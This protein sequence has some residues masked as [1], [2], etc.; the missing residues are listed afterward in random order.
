MTVR[1][2]RPEDYRI[3]VDIGKAFPGFPCWSEQG[4][5]EENN[6]SHSVTLT[7]EEEGKVAGFI[8]FWLV[9]PELQLNLMAV[10]PDFARRGIA[11]SLVKKMLE[12]GKK[13]LCRTVTLEVNE[14]NQAALALYGKFGFHAVG[15]RAGFYRGGGN[16][17]LM[18]AEIGQE[19]I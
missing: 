7:A 9:R 11:S 19:I 2:A 6:N 12:Y 14:N 8:N 13:S 18:N 5:A 1:R 17:V 16:A 15:K 3:F 10:S 4:F